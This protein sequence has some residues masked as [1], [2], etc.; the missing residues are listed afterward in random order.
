[1]DENTRIERGGEMTTRETLNGLKYERS[2]MANERGEDYSGVEVLDSAIEKLEAFSAPITGATNIEPTI[3]PMVNLLPSPPVKKKYKVVR[4]YH[5]S[6]GEEA[7]TNAFNDGWQFVRASEVVPE[8][9]RNHYIHY[10]YI[11]YILCK[12]GD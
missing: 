3:T 2:C 6:N 7:L 12:E 10:A 5:N 8:V 11:E 1:M 4:S 9:N